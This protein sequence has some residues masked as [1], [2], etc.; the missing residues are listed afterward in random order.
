MNKTSVR[1]QILARLRAELDRQTRAAELSRDE[2]IDEHSQPENR[3][4]TH[5]QEAAYLAEGQ[6]RLVKDIGESI[7]LYQTLP[8]PD[9]ANGD[10]IALGALV[11]LDAGGNRSSYF[12]GPRGGG[13]EFELDGRNVL[14]LTPQSP[15]GREL[16]GRRAG[17]LVRL[18]GRTE[19]ARIVSIAEPTAA[20]SPALR[21]RG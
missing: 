17:D 6:A 15:L 18:P 1:E 4:D 9:F 14:V 19:P 11:E 7:E 12:V 5:S 21:G 2:A 3:W 10:A 16:V 13:I 20:V 8:L